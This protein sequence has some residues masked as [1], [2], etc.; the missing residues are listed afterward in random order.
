[1]RTMK[2]ALE[3][4][5]RKELDVHHPVFAWLVEHAADILV[6]CAVG[7]DGRTPYERVKGKRYHGQMH[8]FGSAVRV[9]Y[10]G[11]LQGGLMKERWGSGVWLGKKW[12]SDEHLVS[13]GNGKIVR[14]RDVRPMPEDQAFD[15]EMLLGV[16][17]TPSNPSAAEDVEEGDLPEV[18]RAPIPRPEQPVAPPVPR[19]VIIHRSYLDRFWFYRWLQK[20]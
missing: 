5:I 11:K 7:S 1:M 14:A 2:L 18:P 8:E 4:A 3:A 10:Q 12:A 15:R 9:K 17:G 6:K 20:M 19:R 13:M 16:R